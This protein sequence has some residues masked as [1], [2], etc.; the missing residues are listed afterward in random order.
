VGGV[1]AVRFAL[2]LSSDEL[3]LVEFN[4]Y[5]LEHFRPLVASGYSLEQWA[6]QTFGMEKQVIYSWDLFPFVTERD[7]EQ[8]FI[9]TLREVVYAAYTDTEIG[10]YPRA[11]ANVHNRVKLRL[12]DLEATRRHVVVELGWYGV[13][14]EMIPVAAED[15]HKW[16]P[17]V[18]NQN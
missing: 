11:L 6:H 5:D 13:P 9:P 12:A 17:D 15:P 7:W 4:L 1:G 3:C 8:L 10:M 14:P 16:D 18:A 2:S